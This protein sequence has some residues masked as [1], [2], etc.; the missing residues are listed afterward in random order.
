MKKCIIIGGGAAG[1]YAA[2]MAAQGG[3]E[4]SLWEKNEK[5][6]SMVN[7]VMKLIKIKSPKSV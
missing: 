5:I 6:K 2:V 3:M 7:W 1:M 4:V